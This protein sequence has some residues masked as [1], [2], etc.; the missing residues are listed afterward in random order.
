MMDRMRGKQ[1]M[2]SKQRMMAKQRLETEELQ[3]RMMRDKMINFEPD[4]STRNVSLTSLESQD[5]DCKMTSWSPW[6]LSCSATCGAGY[7]NRFRRVESQ[8]RGRGRPCPTRLEKQ[9][10]CRLPAC[11]Q[12]DCQLVSQWSVWGP[13]TATCGVSGHQTRHRD[14]STCTSQDNIPGIE[15][16]VCLLPCCNIVDGVCTD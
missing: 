1:V 2:M 15:K 9:K 7:K 11:L 10:R 14:L 12:D 8:A 6:S 16:R 3:Q 5:S 13:C 4:S